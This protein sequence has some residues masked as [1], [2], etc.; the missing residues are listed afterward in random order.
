MKKLEKT[1]DEF[2][3]LTLSALG[4]SIYIRIV[5]RRQ[6]LTYK[7]GHRTTIIKTAIMAVVPA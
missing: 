7:D 5:C 3:T 6:I 2:R 4:P 1:R